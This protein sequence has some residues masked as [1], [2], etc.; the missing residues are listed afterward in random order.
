MPLTI[1]DVP[2]V[3]IDVL[4][5]PQL[6]PPPSDN[7][8]EAPAQSIFPPDMGVGDGSTVTTMK[9]VHPAGVVYVIVAV[10]AAVTLP[11][12]TIPEAVPTDATDKLPLLQLPP[13]N[14]SLKAV[15]APPHINVVPVIAKGR[16]FT[17][18]IVF[19]MQPVGNI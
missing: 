1:P 11:P 7:D 16:E 18:T 6:P 9:V 19:V 4:L 8:I 2:A 13:V 12:A 5:L 10:P 3:A 15:V 14:V 17:V